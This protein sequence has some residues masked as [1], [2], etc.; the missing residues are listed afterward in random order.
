MTIE[1][2]AI[3]AKIMIAPSKYCM[4]LNKLDASVIGWV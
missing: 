3:R 2:R 1:R 4:I